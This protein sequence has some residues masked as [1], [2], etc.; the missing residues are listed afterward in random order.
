[1]K[2]TMFIVFFLLLG[3]FFIISEN[4]LALKDAGNFSKFMGIYASWFSQLFQ[5]A[6]S[7]TGNVISMRWLPDENF[8][9]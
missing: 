8:A 2:I 1:M 9:G 3:A 4:N 5:N 7:L 6:G